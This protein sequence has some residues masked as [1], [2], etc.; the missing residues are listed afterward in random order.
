MFTPK[1]NALVILS[2]FKSSYTPLHKISMS[3]EFQQI[4]TV[5]FLSVYCIMLVLFLDLVP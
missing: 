1:S 4:A 5:C 3:G 2:I